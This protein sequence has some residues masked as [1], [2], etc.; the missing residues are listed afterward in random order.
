MISISASGNCNF[1]YVTG[2]RNY[3]QGN[4]V[5]IMKD[6]LTAPPNG[7]DLFNTRKKNDP[8]VYNNPSCGMYLFAQGSD[9]DPVKMPYAREFKE[10]IERDG[11]GKVVEIEPVPNPLHSGHK[12]QLFVWIID[13]AACRSWWERNVLSKDSS[14]IQKLVDSVKQAFGDA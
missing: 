3:E 2:L 5:A 13:H 8:P 7:Y 6:V 11:L 9:D 10:L 4:P 1:K 12:G 14:K